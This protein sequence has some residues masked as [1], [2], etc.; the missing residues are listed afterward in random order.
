MKKLTLL[1]IVG[2]LITSFSK[3]D[4]DLWVDINFTRDSTLWLATVPELAVN[5]F[6]LQTT[7][8]GEYLGNKMQGAFGRFAVSNYEYTPFNAEN[9]EEQFIYAFRIHNNE[10][11][12]WALPGTA[13]VGSLKVNFLCGNATGE[14]EIKVQYFD[15]MEE[16]PGEG[17]EEPQYNEIWKD[18]DPAVVIDVPPHAF[19]TSSFVVEKVLNL[20]GSPKLRLKG[21]TL[22]NV[23][24]YA[25]S[26]S[27]IKESGVPQIGAANFNFKVDGRNI[28][29]VSNI[30][31]YEA[32][33][34][35]LSGNLL[36]TLNK[37]ASYSFNQAGVYMVQIRTNEGSVTRKVAIM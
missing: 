22:R 10:Q 24:I 34:Y 9:L 30:N 21:P 5:Q 29:V 6:S 37:D 19:G 3:A 14:A 25:V 27:K 2:L 32:N 23:H 33:I 8:D 20:T 28:Q 11:S 36:T 35:D 18:F 12:Y 7:L 16:V 15:G 13:D 26:I 17:E 31:V 4:D 1:L